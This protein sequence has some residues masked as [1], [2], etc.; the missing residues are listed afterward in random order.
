MAFALH[1]DKLEDD[2][3]IR[4][5]H[6]FYGETR[7]DCERERDAHGAGCAAFGPALRAD[8]TIEEFEDIDEI[9]EW[10]DGDEEDEDP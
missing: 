8:R 6:I 3:T 10:E 9:P 5:R 1:V 7:E 4:V 2:G